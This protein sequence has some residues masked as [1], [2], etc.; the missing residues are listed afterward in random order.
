MDKASPIFSCSPNSRKSTTPVYQTYSSSSIIST[1]LRVGVTL[2]RIHQTHKNNCP[3][4]LQFITTRDKMKS[5]AKY[6]YMPSKQN[7][8]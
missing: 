5:S 1:T 3:F 7:E 6:I 8:S 4:I 2:K